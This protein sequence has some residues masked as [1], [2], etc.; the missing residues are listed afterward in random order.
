MA[1]WG[2]DGKDGKDGIPQE[3]NPASN[4]EKSKFRMSILWKN[5]GWMRLDLP[6]DFVEPWIRITL[7]DLPTTAQCSK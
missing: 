3:K 2:G 7:T 1:F 4:G 5:P 6:N